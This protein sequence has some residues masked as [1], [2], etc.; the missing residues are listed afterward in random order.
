MKCFYHNA[1]FDGQCSGAIV[2]YRYPNCEMYGI[3]YT[4]KF[5]F[6]LIDDQNE[7]VFMVDFS[8][9]PF[10]EMIKLNNLCELIWIDHHKTAI[11]NARINNFETNGLLNIEK[12]ACELTWD[13]LFPFEEIPIAVEMLG[14]YDIWK[15]KEHPGSLEFQY[16][17]RI[18]E[19]TSP[20]NQIFWTGLFFDS[21]F[22]NKIVQNGKMILKYQQAVNKK[23]MDSYSYSVFFEGLK[24]QCINSNIFNSSIFD[25]VWDNE[26][27]DAMIVY[28]YMGDKYKVSMYTDK[29]GIDV[30]DIC[31]KYGGGGHVQAAG[32]P[33]AKLPK[34]L[35][36]NV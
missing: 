10:R 22:I 18:F 24:C 13:Y 21:I 7:T 12:A 14:R 35:L 28:C 34:D 15:Y 19:D 30:S 9:Q 23:I 36:Q 32:F 20:K 2:K 33:I 27:Y 31:K 4:D 8:I 3:D 26:L 25:S 16:G 17:M 1:D 5:P 29:P 6:E 11:D